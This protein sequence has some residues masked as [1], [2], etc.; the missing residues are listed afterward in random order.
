MVLALAI[1]IGILWFRTGFQFDY[2]KFEIG[3]EHHDLWSKKDDG[4]VWEVWKLVKSQPVV[5]RYTTINHL[6]VIGLLMLLAIILLSPHRQCGTGS[7]PTKV[8]NAL[9]STTEKS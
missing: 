9:P 7:K 1:W 3:D 6:V 2:F 4:L 8:E 5:L